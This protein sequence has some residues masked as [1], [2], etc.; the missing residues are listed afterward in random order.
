MKES[1]SHIGG[2][3]EEE[4]VRELKRLGYRVIERNF[5]AAG[6]EVDVIAE[7]RGV[8]VF[9]EVKARADDRFGS[10]LDAVDRRKQ[11]RIIA[12]ARSFM[13]RKSITDRVVRFDVAAVYLDREPP[14]VTVLPDAFFEGA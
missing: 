6:A 9:V 5:R 11:K 12:A 2:R 1:T 3:G 7:H 10:P 4:A 8:L 14:L 13:A